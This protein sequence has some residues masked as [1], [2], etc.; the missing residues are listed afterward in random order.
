MWLPTVSVVTGRRATP[1]PLVGA[2]PRAVPPSKNVT[3][4]E[5]VEFVA[6]TVAVSVTDCA[7]ADGLGDEVRAVLVDAR[8]TT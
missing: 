3:V 8:L 7:N 2:D 5:G 1:E 4:P 6:V